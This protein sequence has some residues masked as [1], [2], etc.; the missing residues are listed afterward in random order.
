MA[1]KQLRGAIADTITD[2]CLQPAHAVLSHTD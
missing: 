2:V 1:E